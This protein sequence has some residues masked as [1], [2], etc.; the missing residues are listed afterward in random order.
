MRTILV[1]AAGLLLT[2]LAARAFA[3]EPRPAVVVPVHSPCC[4]P[5]LICP[6]DYCPKPWPCFPAPVCCRL[7]DDYCGK[8]LPCRPCPVFGCQCDDYCRKPLPC[9]PGPH[10]SRWLT[11]PLPACQK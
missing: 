2:L 3:A 7:C 11:C 6:D 1:A 4:L 5:C 9:L 8:P 10:W